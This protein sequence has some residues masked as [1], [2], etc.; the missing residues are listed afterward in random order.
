MTITH[1]NSLPSYVLL[2]PYDTATSNQKEIA[3]NIT[4]TNWTWPTNYGEGAI[5][6][7]IISFAWTTNSG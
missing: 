6:G 7:K 3:N 5:L 2:C 1:S 4:V